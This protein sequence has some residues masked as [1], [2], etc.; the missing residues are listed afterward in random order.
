MSRVTPPPRYPVEQDC[1][2]GLLDTWKVLADAEGKDVLWRCCQCGKRNIFERSITRCSEKLVPMPTFGDL[3]RCLHDRCAECRGIIPAVVAALP[4]PAEEQ[5]TETSA[6]SPEPAVQP[7][8]EDNDALDDSSD[9]EGTS[10]RSNIGSTFGMWPLPPT[11]LDSEVAESSGNALDSQALSTPDPPFASQPASAAQEAA[12]TPEPVPDR[13]ESLADARPRSEE[14]Y[15][16]QHGTRRISR[17]S[18][19]RPRSSS[20]NLY[21]ALGFM[22]IQDE[23]EEE[24][25]D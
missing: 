7:Q 9:T 10:A 6:A 12:A 22:S 23:T 21:S 17:L 8:S 4:T 1:P 3:P 13:T 19:T 15:I 25:T 5:V 18:R 24:E 20:D 14:Y 11:A 16:I 2:I